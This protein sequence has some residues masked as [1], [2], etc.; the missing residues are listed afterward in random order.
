MAKELDK[1][2][3]FTSKLIDD[4]TN[5]INDGFIVKR[6]LNPWFKNEAGIRRNGVKFAMTAYEQ[7]EY[8]K[9]KVDIHY[10]SEKYCK[11]KREDGSIGEITL[12]P[13]QKDIMDLYKRPLSILC[14][15][16][17]VGKCSSFNTLVE[18]ENGSKIRIGILY[19]LS[20]LSERKLTILEKIK[21]YLYKLLY[22]FETKHR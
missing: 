8:V 20:I 3:V 14:A 11:I 22:L 15:S 9:C 18:L 7:F 12:R 2:S 4:I 5:K 6:H 13:Y 1:K 17:Q 21:I 19:Y 16:R 10:F